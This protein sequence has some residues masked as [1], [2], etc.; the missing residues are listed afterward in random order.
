MSPSN[1]NATAP[2]FRGTASTVSVTTVPKDFRGTVITPGC[3]IVYTCHN[4]DTLQLTEATV[5]EIL[6]PPTR[7]NS[8]RG[9]NAARP[10][11]R[12][13]VFPIRDAYETMYGGGKLRT[14]RIVTLHAVERVTVVEPAPLEV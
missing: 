13:R 4:G 14:G 7:D 11:Y 5:A 3:T 10:S 12:L 8:R 2:V 9:K 6:P 1:P